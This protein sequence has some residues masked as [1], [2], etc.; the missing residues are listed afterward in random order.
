MLLD[1]RLA[2]RPFEYDQAFDYYKRANAS[3]WVADEVSLAADINDWKT[4]LTEAEKNLIGMVLKGF[5]QAEIVIQDYWATKIPRFFKKPEIQMLAA[6]NSAMEAV[7][8]VAYSY[9]NDSLGL[10]DYSAFL[11][12][13]TAKAKIER[14]INT[15]GKTPVDIAKSLAVFSAFNEGVSLFSSFAILL[16]FSRRN[17]LKGVGQIIEF[18]IRDESLHSEAGCWLFRQLEKEYS[19][20]DTKLREE[21]FDAARTTIELEDDFIEAAFSGG[22]VEGLDKNDMK[23]FIR[24]RTNTKLKDIGLEA[25]FGVDKAA[26]DRMSWF[27]AFSSGVPHTDFFAGRVTTY[28]KGTADWDTLWE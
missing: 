4:K 9:L 5:T 15:K 2:Y 21:L 3:H 28:A 14:L 25:I 18:S 1:K 12:E 8:A 17:L 24:Q 13:P 20:V 26:V 11:S 19:I 10:D 16:S 27:D 23:Q 6:I 7:H 22:P